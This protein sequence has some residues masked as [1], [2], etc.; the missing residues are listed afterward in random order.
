[1]PRAVRERPPVGGT[2][3]RSVFL[4]TNV[5]VDYVLGRDPWEDDA[6]RIMQAISSGRL[7][8]F[9]AGHSVTT[10]FYLVARARDGIV[11]TRAVSLLL[12]IITV[13]TLDHHDFQHAATLSLR[14]FE[15]AV[16]AVACLRAEADVLV[17]RDARD[18]ARAPVN[19]CSPRELRVMLSEAEDYHER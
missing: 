16:Q 18:F 7:R 4:D 10:L 11:A 6:T 1:M 9:V 15:D 19:M 2:A 17:T 12:S 13:V 3:P 8:G 5:L 14:D